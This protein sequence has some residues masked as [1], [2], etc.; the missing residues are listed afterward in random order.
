MHHI[1]K[2]PK[3]PNDLKNFIITTRLA[4]EHSIQNL[5]KVHTDN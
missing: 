3:E 5:H 4:L 2:N 1:T